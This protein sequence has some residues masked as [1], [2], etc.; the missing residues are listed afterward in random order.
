MV[1]SALAAWP[2]LRCSDSAGRFRWAVLMATIMRDLDME[3]E[4]ISSVDE[5]NLQ[6]STAPRYFSR[7][8][9]L[10]CAHHAATAVGRHTIFAKLKSINAKEPL[11]SGFSPVPVQMW[12]AWAQ[13]RCSEGRVSAVPVQM[14]S[15]S[16]V[17]HRRGLPDKPTGCG[18]LACR[19]SF[20][21]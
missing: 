5:L 21:S 20:I 17:L 12:H 11:E 4:K 10:Y 6:A 19:R 16:S 3:S 9:R 7:V 2:F 13:S 18:F 15:G 14:R 1:A 8:H